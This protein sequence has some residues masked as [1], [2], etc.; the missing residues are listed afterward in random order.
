MLKKFFSDLVTKF[1]WQKTNINPKQLKYYDKNLR[2][3]FSFRL[4]GDTVYLQLKDKTEFVLIPKNNKRIKNLQQL[5]VI[6]KPI[7]FSV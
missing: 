6:V 1:F 5:Q 2:K 3:F 4:V 7:S